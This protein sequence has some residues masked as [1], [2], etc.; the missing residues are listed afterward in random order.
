MAAMFMV[1]LT[2]A[3]WGDTVDDYLQ[4]ASKALEAKN[5][6]AA[7]A[8]AGKAV[9][10]APKDARGYHLRGEAH[11]A[12]RDFDAACGDL[13]T[14]L[15][16]D[17]KNGG[18]YHARGCAQFQRGRVAESLADF[19]AF[20]KVRPTSYAGLWQRGI[21]CYY[22]GKYDEGAHQFKGYEEVSTNDVEN[23]VWHF[24]CVARKEGV[25][26]AREKILKV[27]LDDRIPMMK[28]YDLFQGKGKPEDVVTAAEGGKATEAERHERL[29]YGHLYL[30]LYYDAAGDN[31]KAVEHMELAA[32][33]YAMQDY[34][35]DVARV[36]L[37]YLKKGA[38]P[39]K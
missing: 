8:A 23:A 10:A 18:G 30:G 28:V 11:R 26:K 3:A 13:D 1:L 14:C 6:K 35:G 33:K 22:M 7:L 34:M 37:D 5:F 20:L 12:L 29:F 24:L 9:A 19:D 32:G 17:P 39:L 25:A 36:H 2:V 15:R 21:S 16:L 4:E 27:G 38:K 31:K